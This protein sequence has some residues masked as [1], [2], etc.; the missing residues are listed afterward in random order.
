LTGRRRVERVDLRQTWILTLVAEV[1]MLVPVPVPV[2][3]RVLLGAFLVVAVA[4]ALV[5]A[6]LV[7]VVVMGVFVVIGAAGVLEMA[8]VV[9]LLLVVVV[10]FPLWLVLPEL[11]VEPHQPT[12]RRLG[13]C[14]LKSAGG[15]LAG[16]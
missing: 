5:V 11:V 15:V 6:A 12:L 1:R 16:C 3:V 14:R 2:R 7:V 10:V 9:L 4:Q 8:V 13:D